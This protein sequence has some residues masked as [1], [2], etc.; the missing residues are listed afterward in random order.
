VI[1]VFATGLNTVLNLVLYRYFGVRGLAMGHVGAY[2]FAAIASAIVLRRRLGGLDGHRVT[3]S[4]VKTLVAG[5]AAAGSAFLAARLIAGVLGTATLGP[6]A[7]QVSGGLAAGLVTFVLFAV[8]LRIH[9]MDLL[10]RLVT[11]RAKR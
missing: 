5:G 4:I 6:Q 1:N 9:E 7:A 2:T 11:S 8:A 3:R 10:R